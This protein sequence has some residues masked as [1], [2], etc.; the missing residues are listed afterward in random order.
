MTRPSVA[1]AAMLVLAVAAPAFAQEAPAAPPPAWTG[2]I[3][4]GLALTS[5][6]T[7]TSHVNLSFKAVRDP[8]A[9]AVFAA[10]GTYIRGSQDGRRNADNAL[11]NVRG[12]RKVSPRAFWF[13]QLQYL[14]NTFKA[15]NAYWAP[16][17]GVGYRLQDGPKGSFSADASVGASWENNPR[18][19]VQAHAVVTFGEQLTRVLSKTATLTHDFAVTVVAGD[20]TDGLYTFRVGLSVSVT[21]RIQLKLEALDTFQS[22]PPAPGVQKNDVSTIASAVYRF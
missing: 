14:R 10:E 5:G 18:A 20:W 11:V 1:V 2:S 12:E 22:R 6:N 9:K 16:T 15:I 17:I 13:G 3:G 4:A 7:D 21:E 8:R 19:D